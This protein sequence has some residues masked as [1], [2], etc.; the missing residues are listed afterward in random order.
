MAKSLYFSGWQLKRR[1]LDEV[2]AMGA[3]LQH[4]GAS[5]ARRLC[6]QKK[7]A[8]LCEARF[9]KLGKWVPKVAF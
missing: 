9:G 7:S 4:K 2:M 8:L 1:C 6:Y 5:Q 3:P